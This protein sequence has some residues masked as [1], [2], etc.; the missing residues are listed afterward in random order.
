M[1]VRVPFAEG[2]PRGHYEVFAAGFRT[3]GGGTA[4]TWARPSGIAVARDG[5][6]LFA[7]DASNTIWRIAYGR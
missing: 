5:S 7:E 6:L 1:V 3:D 2:R 4:E